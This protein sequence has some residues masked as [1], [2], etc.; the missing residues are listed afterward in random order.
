[1]VGRTLPWLCLW[2]LSLL[3]CEG[4]GFAHASPRNGVVGKRGSPASRLSVT[5]LRATSPV[6]VDSSQPPK[7]ALPCGD[8][9]DRRILT[10]AIPAVLNFA[11][12]PLVGAVDTFWVGRMKEALALAG[13]AA[14]NQVFSSTFWFISFLPSVITPLVAKAVGG[15][16]NE[17]VQSRVGEAMFLGT[18][19]GVIGCTL[20]ALFPTQ[21]LSLVLPPGA[22]ARK[23]AEP[24]LFIRALT[25]IPALL[26][27]VAFAAFRGS[28]DVLTPLK[29]SVLANLIN[30]VLDPIF[31]FDLKM[32]VAGAALAT[33]V[34]EV[35]AF[36]LYFRELFAKKMIS[37]AKL[38]KIPS[39]EA[40]KPILAGGLGI[41][42][43]AI[44]LN[45]SFLAVTRR[46]QALDSSGTAAAAHAITIQ[47]WQLGGVVLLAMSTVG[48]IIVPA[49]VAKSKREGKQGAEAYRT[50]KIMAE[51]M[52]L[53]GAGLGVVLCM[54]QLACLP[55]L[56]SFSPLKEV[57]V[58]ARLPSIIGALLQ[59]INGVVFIGEG[60]QQGNQAFT[61]LA[62][63]T[64]L[65]TGGMLTS[66][67]LYGGTLAGV[68]GSFAVFN[69][70]RLV[71]V[72]RH[73]FFSG[74]FASV[75]ALPAKTK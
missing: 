70:I 67:K 60:I 31:I 42:L 14:S 56:N 62:L 17:A 29:I 46:T 39:F 37:W 2:V 5:A 38:F 8:A 35:V 54:A 25:F 65:A 28:M 19:T 53:W 64:A 50:G 18:L 3:R 32:G 58:A 4:L 34:S 61:S 10:L 44:A 11:I 24:Y 49:E 47:L 63:V 66:L 6:V 71:G 26:S 16:D 21:A 68:W 48:S 27:T 12:L 40:L 41:Q 7:S 69:G 30:I 23:F 22:P 57:Q 59:T 55:L 72:L 36:L 33:C 52:L 51:R 45:I 74:P 9:L 75:K 1:M 73:H 43:R 20:L 13:Q 15:G